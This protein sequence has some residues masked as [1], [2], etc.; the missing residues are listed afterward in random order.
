MR[1]LLLILIA[2]GAAAAPAF[3]VPGG[4]SA[5]P[6]IAAPTQGLLQPVRG[7]GREARERREYRRWAHGRPRDEVRGL[8]MSHRH[9]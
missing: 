8:G 6:A 7:Y 1:G 9:R 5:L 3:A 4:G 2:L